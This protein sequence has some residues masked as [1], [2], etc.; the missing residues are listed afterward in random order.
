MPSRKEVNKDM[1]IIFMPLKD[2]KP[3]EKNPRYNKNAVS[4]VAKSISEYGFN[5]P[6]VVDNENVIITGHT[7]YE[8]SKQL[9]LKVVPVIIA[10]NLTPKQVKAYRIADNKTADFSIW[11]NKLLLE[12]LSELGEEYT[13]FTFA[14]I[15]DLSLLDESDNSIIE[16]NQFGNIYEIVFKSEDEAKIDKIQKLW[17]E[18][19]NEEQGNTDSGNLGKKAGK[20]GSKT[21]R[22][23]Q[24]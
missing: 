17:E 7:R 21:D 2:I 22:K 5:V 14:E 11:D 9:G 1:Q 8:A 6:I 10:K 3:Y 19:E 13:G 20:Q 16:K 18:M 23:D 12:E 15:E 4:E 24:D